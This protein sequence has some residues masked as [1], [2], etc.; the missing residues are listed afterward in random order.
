M[1]PGPSKDCDL[2]VDVGNKQVMEKP[3]MICV[4]DVQSMIGF[5]E[6]EE[7]PPPVP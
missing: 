5:Q 1:I 2:I 6:V 4:V 3:S 7:T